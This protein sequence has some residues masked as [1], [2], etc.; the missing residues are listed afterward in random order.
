LLKKIV[1]YARVIGDLIPDTV[2]VYAKVDFTSLAVGESGII[3]NYTEVTL[4]DKSVRDVNEGYY[5][6][7]SDAAIAKV[8]DGVIT[9]VATGDATITVTGKKS[10]LSQ[11]ITITVV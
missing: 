6:Q 5:Y 2:A 4:N 3:Q 8:T 7:S 1:P 9:A 11:E 10:G